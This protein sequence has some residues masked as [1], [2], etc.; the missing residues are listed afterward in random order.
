M[1]TGNGALC[2]GACH[3]YGEINLRPQA[4]GG[5]QGEFAVCWRAEAQV[6]NKGEA[7]EL[8]QFERPVS[9]QQSDFP[10]R[11]RCEVEGPLQQRLVAR[12]R[13]AIGRPR[14][15]EIKYREWNASCG[16]EELRHIRIINQ[17]VQQL[18][19]GPGGELFEDIRGRQRGQIV[20]R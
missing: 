3:P 20:G 4:D 5:R 17:V 7:V 14:L 15:L 13:R 1:E 10:G 12:R 8:A 2:D 19:I 18:L 6:T 16:A 11:Y 9:R